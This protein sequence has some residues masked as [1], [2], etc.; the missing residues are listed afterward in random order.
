MDNAK[1][2][3][4]LVRLRGKKS[5]EEVAKATGISTSALSMYETGNRVPRDEIKLK[6]AEYYGRSVQFIFF[7]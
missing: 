3:E 2:A 7:N 4:T 5:Q 6:L 1:I